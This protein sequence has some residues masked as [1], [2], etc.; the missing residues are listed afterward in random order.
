MYNCTERLCACQSLYMAEHTIRA[1]TCHQC[2]KLS[3][4]TNKQEF[5][6]GGNSK[7]ARQKETPGSNWTSGRYKGR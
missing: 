6:R 2:Q 1:I 3:F 5:P 4:K 7:Q